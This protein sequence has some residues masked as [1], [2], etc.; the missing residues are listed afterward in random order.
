M[1][2]L[3]SFLWFSIGLFGLIGMLRGFNKEL[4]A[5]GGIILGLFTIVQF[6]SFFEQVGAGA[7]QQQVFYL[8]A[9]FLIAIAFFAYQTPTERFIKKSARDQWQTRTLGGL[10]GGFNG[11]LIFGS[12]WYF[13]DQ[14]E[15]PLDPNIT[16]P[17]LE[18]A[19][20]DM[21]DLLPLV[22]MQQGNLLTLMVIGLFI[23]IFVFVI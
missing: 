11:Y 7:G 15:Y 23:F 12:L 20:A 5:L 14:L 21:V 10:L 8:K 2:Q 4:I 17:S 6:E 22:W 9:I 16:A 18:S 3:S 13:M 19:S 1:I